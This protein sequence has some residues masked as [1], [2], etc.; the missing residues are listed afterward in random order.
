[1][2]LDGLARSGSADLLGF[3]DA[4][5]I[6]QKGDLLRVVFPQ[7]ALLRSYGLQMLRPSL[8]VGRHLGIPGPN[9]LVEAG[10]IGAPEDSLVNEVT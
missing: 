9:V 4:S 1:M 3:G 10:V 5:L 7:P 6:A 2:F 8:D